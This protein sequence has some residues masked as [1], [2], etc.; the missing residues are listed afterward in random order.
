MRK[1]YI[2]LLFLLANIAVAVASDTAS[3]EFCEYDIFMGF[4]KIRISIAESGNATVEGDGWKQENLF[5][6]TKL[7]EEEM[8]ALRAIIESADFFAQAERGTRPLRPGS[9]RKELTVRMKNRKRS[10]VYWQRLSMIPVT[11]FFKKLAAQACAITNLERDSKQYAADIYAALGRKVL[12]PAKLKVPLQEY[13]LSK[14]NYQKK[15]WALEALACTTTPEEFSGFIHRG[16]SEPVNREMFLQIIKT[17][18]LPEEHQKALCPLYVTFIREAY[19]RR[20]KLSQIEGESL[21]HFVRMIGHFQY[22]P[23]MPLFLKWFRE[24]QKPGEVYYFLPLARMGKDGPNELLPYLNNDNI[25]HRENAIE[26][27]KI[28]ARYGPFKSYSD[29]MGVYTT[30]FTE[31]VLPRLREI[32][33]NDQ[34]E[35]MREKARVAI[36]EIEDQIYKH[37]QAEKE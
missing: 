24:S 20:G 5:Y 16:L 36:G 15:V 32:A 13:I 23:A 29:P 19:P 18:N 14:G 12:Q 33:N 31:S 26:L 17:P 10:L 30:F 27:L 3:Y 2:T 6:Q 37:R 34:A 28:A 7:S 25:V 22:K 21:E 35:D 11:V 4:Q 1:L 8:D 9:V